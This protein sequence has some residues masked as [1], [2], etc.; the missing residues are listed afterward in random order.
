MAVNLSVLRAGRPIRP[1]KIPGTQGHMRLERLGHTTIFLIPFPSF[2]DNIFQV[3]RLQMK[4]VSTIDN[5]KTL[6]ALHT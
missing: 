3:R 1:R 5:V 6:C 2:S 4:Y